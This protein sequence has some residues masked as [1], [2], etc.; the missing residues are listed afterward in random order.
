MGATFLGFSGLVNPQAIQLT[1]ANAYR[2]AQITLGTSAPMS[3][4]TQVATEYTNRVTPKLNRY[5]TVQQILGDIEFTQVVAKVKEGTDPTVSEKISMVEKEISGFGLQGHLLGVPNWLL[6]A[7]LGT[8]GYYF[9]KK[10]KSG[11]AFKFF[12]KPVAAITPPKA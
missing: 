4:L 2:A 12:S 8:A 11:G 3:Q 6:Y 1:K 10:K 7:G 9:Y 5:A